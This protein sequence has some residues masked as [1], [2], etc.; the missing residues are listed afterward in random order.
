M[1]C[2]AIVIGVLALD[3]ASPP[4]HRVPR[5][6]RP[7]GGPPRRSTG[8]GAAWWRSLSGGRRS[9]RQS[10]ARAGALE[11]RGDELAEERRRARR[12]RLELRMELAR[13][14]P[15]VVGE[16]DDLDQSALLERPGHD[17]PGVDHPLSK[18]VVHLVAV[19]VS[20]VDDRLGVR[21]QRARALLELDRLG[22]ETHR[23]AEGL[24][25]L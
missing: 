23:P 10:C 13:D 15:R 25:L 19:A 6:V 5:S 9:R 17:E 4:P 18:L 11:S 7:A 8:P 24:D 21:L 22:A 2:L 12:A 1:S 3:R 14:E 20:L 16:L